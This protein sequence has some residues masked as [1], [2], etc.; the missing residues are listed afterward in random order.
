MPET[1]GL[2][3]NFVKDGSEP[4]FRELVSRYIDLV[5]STAL[6]LV[7]GDTHRAQDVSQIVFADLA[8]MAGKLRENTML[9]GWLHRHTCFVART[10]MRGERRREARERQAAEMNSL[11]TH[12]VLAQTAPILDEAIQ[13]LGPDDRDAIL[14]RFYELRNLRS[15]GEALGINENVAQ[16][17]VSRAVNELRV[18]LQ[19]RGVALSTGALA[20]SLAVGAV[21]AAPAGLALSIA[22]TVCGAAATT[23]A[24][25][26]VTVA[27]IPV[28]VNLKI[29][30][31]GAIAVASL[32]TAIVL[33]NQ[34]KARLRNEA[35]IAQQQAEREPGSPAA[36]PATV[37]VTSAIVDPPPDESAAA[38]SRNLTPAGA[39]IVGNPTS[40][41]PAE[42]Q[43]VPSAAAAPLIQRFAA[44]SGSTVRVEGTA[45]AIHP[46]WSLESRV[47]GGFLEVGAGFP[48]RT[49]QEVQTGPVEAKAEVFVAV[50]SLK[51]VDKDGRPYSDTMDEHAYRSLRADQY[52]R[53][54]FRLDQMSFQGMTNSS[55][56]LQYEFMARG[57]LAVAGVT[58]EIDMPVVVLPVGNRKF[59][60]SGQT[61]FK[62]TSF[63]ITPPSVN[64]ALGTLEVGDDVRVAF[65]WLIEAKSAPASKAQEQLVPL[66][67]E[68][69]PPAFRGIPRDLRLGSN[70]EPL[71][72]EPR[73]PMIV[74][75][76]VVNL[77]PYAQLSSSDRNAGPEILA[78]IVD[79]DK[80]ASEQSIIF[81]RKGTQWIQMDFG[82]LQEIFAVVIWHA[83]NSAKVYHGVAAGVADDPDFRHNVRT[84]FNNDRESSSGLGRGSN[85]EYVESYE[86]KLING[87]GVK[88]RYLRFYSRGSTESALNEYTEIEVYGRPVL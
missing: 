60:I 34:S 68:L 8:R 17:R 53:L 14:L 84:L 36:G 61:S 73:P 31:V 83:H 7:D 20:G 78:R 69:P 41:A 30:L 29:A 15:V 76:N 86:G 70:V 87:K 42:P 6:R 24:S 9:G 51:S 74:P 48:I 81:L 40:Q 43:N 5:Y 88:A 4:A 22:G 35:L 27:K 39:N 10:M 66:V 54:Y 1:Q 71:S 65:D 33:H 11:E 55:A 57:E 59:K 49:N 23:G 44:T 63:Q 79:G 12:S 72:K 58:N 28:M 52:P 56:I 75:A 16:K 37:Q 62:M 80:G 21:K 50:R 77:A 45:N 82:K 64:F 3:A 67:L 18:L 13:K 26:G 47:I 46:E 85:R 32:V 38:P 19:R 2:L 25:A